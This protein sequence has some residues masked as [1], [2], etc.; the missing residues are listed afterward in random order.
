VPASAGSV[1]SARIEG[2]SHDGR[3]ITRVD[4]KVWFVEGG[5]PGETVLVKPICGKRSYSLGIAQGLLERSPA[6]VDPRCPA[7]GVCGGCALQHIDYGRQIEFKR[8]TVIEALDRVGVEPPSEV[9]EISATPW[10]YRR[11]A[12]LGVRLVPKKGGVLVG[13]R[14]RN[15]SFITP[16]PTCPVIHESVDR[17]LPKLPTLIEQLS[18]PGQIPQ[19]EIAAGENATALVFRHLSALTDR[20]VARLREFGIQEHLLVY[21]QAKGPDTAIPVSSEDVPVLFY[22][23]KQFDL[24]I[25]FSVTDFIQ[26]NAEVNERIVELVAGW[27]NPGNRDRVLDLFCGLG[28]FS[29]ALS[30]Q[31]GEVVGVE[32]E[33]ALVTQA[34]KNAAVNRIANTRFEVL[35][36]FDDSI[37]EWQPG[38]YS[39]VL[40]DP[41]RSGAIEALGVANTHIRPRKIAYVS[42]NPATFARD[43]R[44]LTDSGS[45]H[46]TR[47]GVADMF[48]HTS[49][50][51]TVALFV[52]N[53]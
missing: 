6:R 33:A 48:P 30:R 36:L 32:G 29:L 38:Q 21:S 17:V 19:I 43:A 40:L 5:L 16:L 20:D 39:H 42:C 47:L 49:H 11:R 10:S 3:G 46:L 45:Y 26:V 8:A 37:A 14:E 35:D 4:G 53:G 15:K 13:F 22:T 51:E 44:Y 1:F 9:C 23:L 12:R 34:T 18:I 31:S 27:L 2:L 50:V 52:R 24:K 25:C 28:N 7:F 41:P